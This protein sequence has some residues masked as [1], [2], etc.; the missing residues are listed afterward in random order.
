MQGIL[1]VGVQHGDP[2]KAGDTIDTSLAA[3]LGTY[4]FGKIKNS[5]Y[6]I[7]DAYGTFGMMWSKHRFASLSC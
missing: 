5:L 6:R 7:V 1:Q 3:V 2:R 4:N